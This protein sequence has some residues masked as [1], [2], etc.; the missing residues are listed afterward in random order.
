MRTCSLSRQT[1]TRVS[2][3]RSRLLPSPLT[4]TVSVCFLSS[5]S[6]CVDVSL[7][8]Q[9]HWNWQHDLYSSTNMPGNINSR[10]MTGKRLGLPVTVF[11]IFRL[12]C[13]ALWVQRFTQVHFECWLW[14]HPF[15]CVLEVSGTLISFESAYVGNHKSLVFWSECERNHKESARLV[16]SL[17]LLRW[18]IVE[19]PY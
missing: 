16:S 17:K 10:G 18:I 2:N 3:Q 5:P 19:H 11:Y 9:A 12:N 8:W 13:S 15:P 1:H 7:L 6:G 14:D 4:H